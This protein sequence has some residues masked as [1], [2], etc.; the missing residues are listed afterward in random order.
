[1]SYK[2]SVMHN[3]VTK[4]P[5]K[6]GVCYVT[7]LLR[8]LRNCYANRELRLELRDSVTVKLA[9]VTLGCCG[10]CYALSK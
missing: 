4:H 8:L 5:I 3:I 9:G 6:G 7:L 2:G 10:W 1:M